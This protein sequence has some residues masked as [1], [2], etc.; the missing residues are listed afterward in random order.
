MHLDPVNLICSPQRYY[1]NADLLRECFRKLGAYV[2]SC[3]AKDIILHQRLTTHLDE[4]APGKRAL[5]YRTYLQELGKLSPDTPPIEQDTS[6]LQP[7]AVV[8]RTIASLISTGT[9]LN[10]GF[11]ADSIFGNQ[12]ATMRWPAEGKT[13]VTR[14]PHRAPARIKSFCPNW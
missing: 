2:K 3:H 7:D 6:S 12:E 4:C 5:D 13:S 9:E 8:G 10:A 14:V 1:R 11:L